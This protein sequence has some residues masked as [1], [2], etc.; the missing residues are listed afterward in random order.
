MSAPHARG[1][2]TWATIAQRVTPL[3][4]QRALGRRLIECLNK[5]DCTRGEIARLTERLAELHAEQ[6]AL[7][8]AMSQREDAEEGAP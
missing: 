3:V 8:R 4:R 2:E 7:E 6:D 1:S 5:R